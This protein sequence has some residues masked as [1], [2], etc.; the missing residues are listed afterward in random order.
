MILIF[1]EI[2]ELNFFKLQHNIK[3]NIELR[4]TIDLN[5]T[6]IRYGKEEEFAQEED[7]D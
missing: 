6:I 2:I 1:N 7:E 5:D 3:K 4:A